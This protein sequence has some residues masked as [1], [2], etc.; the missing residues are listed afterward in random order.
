[1]RGDV[2]GEIAIQSVSMFDGYRQ[3]PE[4]TFQVLDGG[5]YYSG[6]LGFLVGDDL[7]VIGRMKISLSWPE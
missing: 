4:K 6:D 5:W 7:F 3:L 2:V 1:V